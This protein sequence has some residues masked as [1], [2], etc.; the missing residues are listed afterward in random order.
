MNETNVVL[1]K[2]DERYIEK[3]IELIR[4]ELLEGNTFTIINKNGESSQSPETVESVI[5][6]LSFDVRQATIINK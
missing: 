3:K 5:A 6:A 2:K 4:K 1:T